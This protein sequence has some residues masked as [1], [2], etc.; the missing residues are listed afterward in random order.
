MD[1]KN[2]RPAN[3]PSRFKVF[4]SS[5]LC[6]L[7]IG[8]TD[9]IDKSYT[10]S[11]PSAAME[12][13]RVSASLYGDWRYPAQDQKITIGE[14]TAPYDLLV[15]FTTLRSDEVTAVRF[16][17]KE[18]ASETGKVYLENH[19]ETVIP[20]LMAKGMGRPELEALGGDSGSW[21]RF[22]VK[23]LAPE[24]ERLRLTL[25]IEVRGEEDLL[26]KQ[27]VLLEFETTYSETHINK[28]FSGLMGI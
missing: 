27:E 10:Y 9:H 6:I 26:E 12:T 5:L 15:R 3:E 14:Y 28:K 20:E 4:L 18:L 16:T 13:G 25:E 22:S 11:K 21:A 23:D 8:C 17:V 7:G 19:S 1:P 2:Q 24:Y